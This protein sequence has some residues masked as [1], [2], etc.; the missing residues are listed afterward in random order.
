MRALEASKSTRRTVYMRHL[1][2]RRRIPGLGAL[3]LL[4]VCASLPVPAQAS[5]ALFRVQRFFYSSPGEVVSNYYEPR[6]MAVMQTTVNGAKVT[7]PALPPAVGYVFNV[8]NRFV[9]PKAF[10]SYMKRQYCG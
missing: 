7:R 5:R 10:I 3:A 9:L 4:A 8:A 2:S 1:E 6:T